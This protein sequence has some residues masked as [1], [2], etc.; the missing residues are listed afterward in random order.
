[1]SNNCVEYTVP[2]LIM[3]LEM[4]GTKDSLAQIL[5]FMNISLKFQCEQNL[6]ISSIHESQ[7]VS[8]ASCS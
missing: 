1:M 7:C 8:L 3:I 4:N 6:Q 5:V 2:A